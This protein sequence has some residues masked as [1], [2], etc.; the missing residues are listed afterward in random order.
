MAKKE[1]EILDLY[2]S[3]SI[4]MCISIGQDKRD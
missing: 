2:E 3:W 1:S 4:K